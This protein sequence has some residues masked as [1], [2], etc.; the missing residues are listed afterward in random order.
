VQTEA[1]HSAAATHLAS[2]QSEVSA[3]QVSQFYRELHLQV[4]GIKVRLAL[5]PMAHEA[6]RRHLYDGNTLGHS[7]AL[8]AEV[9]R[10]RAE[11]EAKTARCA[12]LEGQMKELSVV[13]VTCVM[14]EAHT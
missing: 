11:L 8:Q 13:S 9:G 2:A 3:L 14:C 1:Q 12:A 5:L 6:G 4:V 7:A 10:L